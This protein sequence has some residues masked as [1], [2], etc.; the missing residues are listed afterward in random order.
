[1]IASRGLKISD[2][3]TYRIALEV[4]HAHRVSQMFS[5]G[6]L[7]ATRRA[8][9]QPDVVMLRA[10]AVVL[11]GSVGIGRRG[12]GLGREVFLRYRVC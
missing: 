2:W 6:A 8:S 4:W 7:T 1:M 3:D 10:R 5:Y 12:H 11:S 9:Y